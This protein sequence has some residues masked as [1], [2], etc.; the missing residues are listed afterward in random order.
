MQKCFSEHNRKK[1]KKKL[2]LEMYY[3]FQI[4]FVVD[5]NI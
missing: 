3:N 5:T 1:Y 2:L 4:I